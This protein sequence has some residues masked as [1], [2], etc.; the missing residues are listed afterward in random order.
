M[1]PG[2][3]GWCGGLEAGAVGVLRGGWGLAGGRVAVGFL[4]VRILRGPVGGGFGGSRAAA[5][6]QE[7]Q[8][9]ESRSWISPW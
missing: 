4:R 9:S 5:L 2:T 3:R 7:A 6:A 1:M 8:A